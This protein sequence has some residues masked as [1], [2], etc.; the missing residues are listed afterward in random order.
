MRPNVRR[1]DRGPAT[2]RR[3]GELARMTLRAG[4]IIDIVACGPLFVA[5]T[6][7]L[8]SGLRTKRATS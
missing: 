1:A 7:A 5:A 3:H 6:A 8:A 4:Q 2:A